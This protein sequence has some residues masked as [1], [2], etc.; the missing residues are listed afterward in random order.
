MNKIIS[1]QV[2]SGGWNRKER[3]ML[4]KDNMMRHIKFLSYL[5][6]TMIPL[7]R[8]TITKKNTNSRWED[9]L[10]CSTRGR[11]IK[12]VQPKTLKKE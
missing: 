2:M 1:S 10:L 11:R 12:Q 3:Y 7:F 5:I 9:N 8:F 4:E 6:K